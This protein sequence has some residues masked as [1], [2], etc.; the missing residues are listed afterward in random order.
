MDHELRLEQTQ[1]LIMTPELRQAIAVLQLSSME[2]AEMVDRELLENPVLEVDE[3][4]EE[5]AAPAATPMDDALDRYFAWDEYFNDGTD[6]GYSKGGEREEQRSYDFFLTNCVTLQ[7]HL[8]FQLHL[9]VL[10]KA[11]RA[12]GEY[13]IGC[14]DDNGYLTVA[15][16]DIARQWEIPA[17][18]VEE[19]LAVI[20]TFDPAGVGARNLAEC[21]LLQI[22]GRR[23]I[24]PLVTPIIR[25]FLGALAEG[26]IQKIAD[27]LKTSPHAVQ[28]AAD[29]I[30]RLNPKPGR[31]FGGDNGTRYIVPDAVIE[32][33]DDRYVVVVNESSLPR[34]SINT[35]Y[36][37]VAR[38][39]D[40]QV[41]K[42]I[43][44][45]LNAAVW[46]IKSIEQRRCTLYKVI[47]AIAE[48]QRD[49][50]DKGP[51]FLRP[52]TLKHVADVVGVH[53]STVSRATHNK[54]VQTP[55]GVFPLRMFFSSAVCASEGAMSATSIKQ[56]LK[57]MIEGEEQRC[58]LSDRDIAAVFA[59]RG[60]KLSRRTVAKYREEMGIPSSC[61][62]RR[63]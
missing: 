17:A 54:Y 57:T 1:K 9:A 12:L 24:H 51:Q 41:K 29:I 44:G 22:Q 61:R 38:E 35:F 63:Y 43:E 7:E 36:R 3:E 20:Q 19:V 8:L 48:L 59:A 10:D 11:Q 28:E 47:S 60:I 30:R 26:K 39:G 45:R 32:R 50:L 21:L 31:E 23:E 4:E 49:F 27:A 56:M 16:A 62:R 14:I 34:L 37:R 53:E 46:L 5:E 52:L 33:V 55:Q 40:E 6:L 2:L 18:R 15:V 58:P 13:I 25:H 42:Y